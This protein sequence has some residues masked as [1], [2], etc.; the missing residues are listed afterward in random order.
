MKAS[1]TK[2]TG[3]TG[4]EIQYSTSKTFSNAKTVTIK[5]N[6]TTSVTIKN[7]SAN[8]TYYVRMRTVSGTTYSP[9]SAAYS[10]K[11]K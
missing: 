7:T 11:A 3:A 6:A 9:W 5:S 8:K 1:W 10:V 2:N 4:Y